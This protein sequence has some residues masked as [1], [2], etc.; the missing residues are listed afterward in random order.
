MRKYTRV[1]A[2][3]GRKERMKGIGGRKEGN[4]L[5]ETN[6]RNGVEGKELKQRK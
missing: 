5:E 6:R 4:E 1:G 2:S 3:G